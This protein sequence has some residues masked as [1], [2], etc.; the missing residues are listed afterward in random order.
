MDHIHKNF[1]LDFIKFYSTEIIKNA[2]FYDYE[3]FIDFYL[4]IYLGKTQ[5]EDFDKFCK[6]FRRRYSYDI[7]N[8]MLLREHDDL[9]NRII[10]EI[11][12]D[13]EG[14]QFYEPVSRLTFP[15]YTG[16][17]NCLKNWG[18]E[19]VVHIHTLNHDLFI[20]EFRNSEYL[21]GFSDGFKEEGSPFYCK[22]QNLRFADLNV[23]LRYFADK[24]DT[25]YRLYKLHG[26]IDQLSFQIKDSD[27]DF[28]FIKIKPG[29]SRAFLSKEVQ[30][31]KGEPTYKNVGNYFP[32]D[33]L[34][35]TT[36]KILRYNEGPYYKKVFDHFKENLRNS[37]LL[38]I[39]GYGCKDEGINKLIEE[40]YSH[41]RS[42]FIIDPFPNED[43]NNFQKKFKAKLRVKNPE[44]MSIE[45][46]K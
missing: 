28:P 18:V 45:D 44:K 1:T 23:R 3:E 15:G 33:F 5:N 12:V 17:H 36:S 7:E 26:S 29:I 31:E 13:N 27:V 46:F 34:R 25:K 10:A 14:V 37:D 22:F 41:G 38:V 2:E 32:S 35:G 42:I 39:I 4:E 8:K 16:F 30:D 19:N 43:I 6:E 24:Y 9:F 11:L 20:E 21:K 40:N